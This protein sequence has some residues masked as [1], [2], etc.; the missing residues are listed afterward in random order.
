M[1]IREK[2]EMWKPQLLEDLAALVAVPS[3]M[4]PASAEPQAP[5]EQECGRHLTHLRRLPKKKG[6]RCGTLTAMRWMPGWAKGRLH[7]CPGTS[8]VVEA[9]DQKGWDSDPF[10]MRQDGDLLMVA[11]S[12]MT[13]D[14]CWRHCMRPG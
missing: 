13:K 11:G 2:I 7:R 9:R 4:D 6:F 1:D 12:M 10:V 3:V 8:D 14:R 5:L